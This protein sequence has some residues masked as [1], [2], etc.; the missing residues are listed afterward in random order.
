MIIETI[1][2]SI[3]FI[4]FIFAY[5]IQKIEDSKSSDTNTWFDVTVRLGFSIYSWI[6]FIAV[7]LL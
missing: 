5:V 7:F 1:L 4:G 6:S 3:Y 2:W